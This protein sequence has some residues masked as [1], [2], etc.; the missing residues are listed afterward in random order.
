VEVKLSSV[1]GDLWIGQM[2][3]EP[4]KAVAEPAVP[5]VPPEPAVPPVPPVPPVSRPERLTTAEILAM[6]ERGELSVDE[7]IHRMQG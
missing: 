7:A 6:V 4:G 3:E 2:G 1:S 5:P